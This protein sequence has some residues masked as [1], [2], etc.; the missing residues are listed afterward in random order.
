[1]HPEIT[2]PTEK[3]RIIKAFLE[4]RASVAEAERKKR[5]LAIL[6][7][8]PAALIGVLYILMWMVLRPK[9]PPEVWFVL[10]FGAVI[11]IRAERLERR[12]GNLERKLEELLERIPKRENDA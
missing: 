2:D 11:A 10:A 6:G 4:R 7:W 9:F 8:A 12:I 5:W 3:E 1:M